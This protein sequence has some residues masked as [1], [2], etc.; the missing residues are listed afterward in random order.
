MPRDD[1]RAQ[2]DR[3]GR[4]RDRRPRPSASRG[5][6]APTCSRARIAQLVL[7]V[8]RLPGVKSVQLLDQRRHAARPL[9]GHRRDAV[10]DHAPPTCATAD[11]PPPKPPPPAE[12]PTR[13]R[14]ARAAAPARRPRLPRRAPGST[15][16]P[17]SRRASPSWRSRSGRGSAATASRARRPRRRSPARSGR[18]RARPA[19]AARVEVLLDRQ[20]ALVIDGGRVVRTLTS[21]SRRG[22]AS[23]RRPAGSPCSARSELLVGARTRSGCRGRATSSAA[24]RSTSRPTCRASRRRTA[25]C[26]CRATTRSGS[27]T[28][29]GRHAGDRA[30]DAHDARASRSP[31][32]CCSPPRRARRAPA[33]LPTLVAR[34]SSRSALSMPPPGFQVGSVRGP[35]RASSP[36]A[37]SS[38][39][40]RPRP[41]T[42]RADRPLRAGGPLLRVLRRPAPKAWDLALSQITIT[43]AREADR[44]LLRAV[45]RRRPGRAARARAHARE[46]PPLRACASC[47]LCAERGTTGAEAGRGGSARSGPVRVFGD[48]SRLEAELYQR[49]C[50]AV[51][52]DAAA[53]R[54]TPRPGT[55][56]AS[57]SSPAGSG[58]AS[59]TGPSSS[60]GSALRAPVDAALAA[61]EEDG[62]LGRLAAAWLSTDVTRL[63][64][65]PLRCRGPRRHYAWTVL[66][67]CFAAILFAQGLRLAFGAF[68]RPWE[69]EFDVSRGTITLIGSPLVPRLRRLAAVRRPGGRSLRHPPHAR[70]EHAAR[71]RRAWC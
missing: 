7:T 18:R 39:S 36:R 34:A 62:T 35:R 67:L 41:R 1:R 63:Q 9:P 50:D 29:S 10:P 16:R 64:R 68:V 23:R 26:A 52:G 47:S 58:R 32:R 49:R 15:A 12:E 20:L 3:G 70:R 53:A 59:A 38:T 66:A 27:T 4:R 2:R 44:R 30:R 22:R 24:S 61:L 25:A 33:P 5:R 45:P 40:P 11:V 37:T 43:A 28:G 69:E 19:A 42:R 21:S 71:R 46:A 8:D 51:V 6:R 55:P 13:R 31:S 14:R 54:R 60:R 56:S 65:F 48:A 57:A 17:A